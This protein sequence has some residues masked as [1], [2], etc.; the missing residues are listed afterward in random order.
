MIKEILAYVANHPWAVMLAAFAAVLL[1]YFLIRKIFKLG[2]LL[3]L[4][5]LAI[6]GYYYFKAP[7]D[8]PR[9][10]R[11][12]LQETRDKSAQ[13]LKK[14]K[15]TFKKSKELYEKSKEQTHHVMDFLQRRE[16]KQLPDEPTKQ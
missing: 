6:S 1:C 3:L 7:Q 11:Q 8:S 4:I 9:N 13:L 12:A 14:G 16:E 5:L 15:E 2:L 10:F